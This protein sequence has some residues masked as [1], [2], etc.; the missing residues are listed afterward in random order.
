[1]RLCILLCGLKRTYEQVKISLQENL[2]NVLLQQSELLDVFV[3]SDEAIKVVNLRGQITKLPLVYESIP[4][5]FSRFNE[6]YYKL[7][8]PYMLRNNLEYDY[9]IC[10]RP[11]NFY[12]KHCLKLQ[13][14]EWDKNKVSVRMRYYPKKLNLF[15]HTGYLSKG[16]ETV[17]DQFYI[18][19]KKI[20]D[21]A[22]SL[23]T[24]TYPILSKIPWNEGDL[25]RLWN[26]NNIQFTTFPINVIIHNWS[27]DRDKR[28]YNQRL[29]IQEKQIKVKKKE[30]KKKLKGNRKK[31]K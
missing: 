26:S 6:C 29:L 28:I 19:P 8:L 9:Y 4:P 15:R 17:D 18:I 30:L 16:I 22:F 14:N 31:K 5:S 2:I 1:M 12:F 21:S 20:A 24:G 7:I 27:H 23:I 10:T 3:H 13:I 25:T 11:D